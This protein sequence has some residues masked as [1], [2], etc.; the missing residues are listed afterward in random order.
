[1]ETGQQT[2]AGRGGLAGFQAGGVGA[3]VFGGGIDQG[4]GVFPFLNLTP[5][6]SD[7]LSIN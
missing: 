6:S 2:A 3:V 5:V 7:N 4:V 1:M